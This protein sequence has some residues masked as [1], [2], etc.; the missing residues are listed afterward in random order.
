MYICLWLQVEIT[1]VWGEEN[2]RWKLFITRFFDCELCHGEGMQPD[3]LPKCHASMREHFAFAS[4]RI[5]R[6]AQPCAR[7]SCIAHGMYHLSALPRALS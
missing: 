4:C 3:Q 6:S 7:Q 5:H 1:K 2:K